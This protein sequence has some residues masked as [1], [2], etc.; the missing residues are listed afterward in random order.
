MAKSYHLLSEEMGSLSLIIEDLK[1]LDLFLC[2][3]KTEM[4]GGTLSLGRGL[5][6][7]PELVLVCI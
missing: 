1:F 7:F 5:P 3:S 2:R 4:T 6:W